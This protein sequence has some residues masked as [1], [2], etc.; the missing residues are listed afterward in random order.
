MIRLKFSIDLKYEIAA[1]SN[2]RQRCEQPIE[3]RVALT[4]RHRTSAQSAILQVHAAHARA[5]ST[6][7]IRRPVPQRCAVARVVVHFDPRVRSVC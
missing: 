7:F 6:E 2:F 1:V 3:V 4:Q 5:V